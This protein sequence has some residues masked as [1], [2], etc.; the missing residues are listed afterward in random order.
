MLERKAHRRR[1]ALSAKKRQLEPPVVMSR[2]FSS[3]LQSRCGP[4]GSWRP[5][6]DCPGVGVLGRPHPP[7]ISA[8]CQLP[9]HRP[10]RPAVSPTT[11][12][13]GHLALCVMLSALKACPTNGLAN[14]GLP[15]SPRSCPTDL[16]D[17]R[18]QARD[19]AVNSQTRPH[20]R[21]ASAP[22]VPIPCLLARTCRDSLKRLKK[23]QQPMVESD[24]LND[25][26]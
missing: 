9:H 4:S 7:M 20:Y 26:S 14:L 21:L 24:D 15:P 3:A 2:D 5:R 12:Q 25:Q 19:S 18:K 22:R 6:L 1:S 10:S 13:P 17:T 8:L 16:G 23:G 11:W